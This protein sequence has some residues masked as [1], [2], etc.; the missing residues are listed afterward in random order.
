[1]G[2]I[3][4]GA[5]LYA[6]SLLNELAAR[7]LRFHHPVARQLDSIQQQRKPALQKIHSTQIVELD[8]CRTRS[9]KF[10]LKILTAKV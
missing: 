1:V 7:K 8:L 3:A 10:L 9:F 4:T 5:G 6:D 2:E